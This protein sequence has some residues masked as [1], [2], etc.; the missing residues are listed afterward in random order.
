MALT[1]Y[2]RLCRGRRDSSARCWKLRK[3]KTGQMRRLKATASTFCKELGTKIG[4]EIVWKWSHWF[5]QTWRRLFPS[6]PPA[7]PSGSHT[8]SGSLGYWRPR[9]DRYFPSERHV[10]WTLPWHLCTFQI[11]TP[12][13][14]LPVSAAC[15]KNNKTHEDVNLTSYII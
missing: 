5:L 1:S 10:V 7:D 9:N 3:E 13:L 12:V 14:P 8:Q 11:L 4:T 15:K 2:Q 6:C